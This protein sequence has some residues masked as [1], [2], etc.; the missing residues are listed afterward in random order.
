MS[1]IKQESNGKYTV[2]LTIN[3]KQIRFMGFTNRREAQR[4][5]EHIE[6]LKRTQKT[7]LRP[8]EY[9]DEW[10]NKMGNSRLRQRLVALGIAPE[11]KEAHTLL[12]L[13]KSYHA[14]LT[15]A[16]DSTWEN[17]RSAFNNLLAFFPKEA[18]VEEITPEDA[19]SYNKWLRTKPLNTRTLTPVPL[20]TA[21]ANR[22]IGV[23]KQLFTYAVRIGWIARNPFEEVKGGESANPDKLAYIS[24]S[25]VMTMLDGNTPYWRLI[26]ALGR[27]CGL[28]GPSEMYDLRWDD[29]HFHTDKEPGWLFIAAKKNK[30]HGRF[31][32]RIPLPEIVETLF[33]E[34]RETEPFSN[35][36]FPRMR[37]DQ[38]FSV[39]MAR[40]LDENGL[41]A[42]PNPWYNLRKS[43]CSDLLEQVQDIPVY[44]HIADHNYKVA[45][46]HYQILHKGRMLNAIKKIDC[47]SCLK[48]VL[49]RA[50]KSACSASSQCIPS[51]R[52]T[53]P[54]PVKHGTKQTK[55]ESSANTCEDSLWA[56]QDSNLGPPPYQGLGPTLGLVCIF[57]CDFHRLSPFFTM[58]NRFSGMKLL[59]IFACLEIAKNWQKLAK[60]AKNCQKLPKTVKNWQVLPSFWYD[61]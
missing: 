46:K 20:S 45:V 57:G 7:G 53:S 42:Y 59:E 50:K 31:G 30:C 24:A 36:V 51:A 60:T 9:I 32:R 52:K 1:N 16:Q 29:V 3:G 23:V 28:R 34:Y 49:P 35:K 14:S 4:V 41:P 37:P 21:T 39:M 47:F 18:Q 44:E 61:F 27:F 55:K 2:R 56:R 22:R 33:Q 54:N 6:E 43:F 40:F 5:G 38:N 25:E 19:D 8:P 11:V 48:K 10:L 13:I 12:T 26:L 58:F 17:Y 15:E